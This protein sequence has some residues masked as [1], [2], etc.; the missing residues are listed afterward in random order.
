M[1]LHKNLVNYVAIVI[2]RAHCS[3]VFIWF[4]TKGVSIHGRERSLV[5]F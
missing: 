5:L 2:F 1:P 3:T 4:L